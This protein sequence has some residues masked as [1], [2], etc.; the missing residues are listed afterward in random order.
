MSPLPGR[1]WPVLSEQPAIGA[2]RRWWKLVALQAW[3]V[4]HSEIRAVAWCDDHLCAPAR[5]AAVR[6]RFSAL[7]VDVLLIAPDT[8]VGL[9][10]EHLELLTAWSQQR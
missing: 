7:G 8:V 1:D 5:A 9:T 10:P 2:A 3:L 4:R 6:R